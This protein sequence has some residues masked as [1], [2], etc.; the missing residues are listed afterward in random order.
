MAKRSRRTQKR[1][2]RRKRSRK[3]RGRSRRQPNLSPIKLVTLPFNLLKRTAKALQK[4]TTRTRK[5]PKRMK[6]SCPR[7]HR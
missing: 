7:P 1:T 6:R 5:S 4:K 3:G 2:M